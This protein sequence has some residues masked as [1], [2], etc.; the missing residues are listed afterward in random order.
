MFCTI[1]ANPRFRPKKFLLMDGEIIASYLNILCKS[2]GV[3]CKSAGLL[4]QAGRRPRNEHDHAAFRAYR[5]WKYEG[6]K[7]CAYFSESSSAAP[8]RSAPFIARII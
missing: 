6:K 5:W 3:F 8:S 1:A 2:F 4:T 7:S